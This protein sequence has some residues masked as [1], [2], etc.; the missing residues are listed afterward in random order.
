MGARDSKAMDSMQNLIQVSD[1]FIKRTLG[2]IS[3]RITVGLPVGGVAQ[4]SPELIHIGKNMITAE[5]HHDVPL[6]PPFQVQFSEFE[7]QGTQI[8]GRVS[9]LGV[10]SPN[11]LEFLSHLATGLL[12][13]VMRGVPVSVEGN[14][15]TVD[16]A[17][18]LPVRGVEITY[19]NIDEGIAVGFDYR[20]V[21]ATADDSRH[22]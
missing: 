13:R 7:A 5:V 17:R 11:A 8:R 15:V 21:R 22:P 20:Q 3:P 6:L 18:W 9:H 16:I 2:E 14:L 1:A 19:L 4:I 12:R 10:L